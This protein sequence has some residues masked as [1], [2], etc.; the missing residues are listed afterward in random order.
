MSKQN[1]ESI[2]EAFG[3]LHPLLVNHFMKPIK[4]LERSLLPPGYF[5]VLHCLILSKK[6]VISMTDL[7]VYSCTSK[8]NLTTMV[9]RL[10]AEGL[11]ERFPDPNDRRIVNVALTEK[12]R[13]LLNGLKKQVDSL[14]NKKLAVLDEA[15]MKK[16]LDAMVDIQ[17]VL[18][19][20]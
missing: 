7:S 6:K 10:C 18:K 14:V 19:K 17:E 8:P 20:L 1:P 3:A 9:D 11:L 5:H 13:D 12:A 16:L 2:S 4:G 15:D